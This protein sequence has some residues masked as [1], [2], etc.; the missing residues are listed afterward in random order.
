MTN[1]DLS[2]LNLVANVLKG[3]KSNCNGNDCLALTPLSTL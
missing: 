1:F 2:K 3:F